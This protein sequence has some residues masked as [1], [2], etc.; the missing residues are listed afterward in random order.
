MITQRS[1]RPDK[2]ELIKKTGE[3]GKCLTGVSSRQ[4]P[5]ESKSRQGDRQLL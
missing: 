5:E 2:R 3:G 1:L 4:N